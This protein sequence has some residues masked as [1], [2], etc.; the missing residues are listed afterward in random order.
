MT[1]APPLV[2]IVVT[3]CNRLN[4]LRACVDSV[5]AQRYPK[6]RMELIIVDDCST[7]GTTGYLRTL[8]DE[9]WIQPVSLSAKAQYASR[10][11]AMAR[12][13]GELI[14]STDDDCTA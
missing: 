3:T 7:D 14:V 2:S 10:N 8:A 4:S 1:T 12:A 13:R 11:W 9:P 5:R 6:E